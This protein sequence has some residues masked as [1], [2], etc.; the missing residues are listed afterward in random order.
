MLIISC[1]HHPSFQQIG[2]VDTETGECGERKLTHK[3]EA[4]SF[5]RG[6]NLRIVRV[7]ME[8][9]GHARWFERLLVELNFE[10]WIDDPA[11]IR[12]QR[13]R[14]QKTDR[15]D[16]EHL[17]RL[18]VEN[19]FHRIWYPVRKIVICGNCF[20]TDIGWCRC[21]RESR[22]SCRRLP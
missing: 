4:E 22:T 3:E 5:Y 14:K 6:L 20:G 21:G 16:A 11:Q 1:D 9:T 13:V 19:R 7:G 17:L 10:L 12:A 15:Q 18:L 2:F 8:A